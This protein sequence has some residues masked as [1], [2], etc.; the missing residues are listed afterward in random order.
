MNIEREQIDR[1]MSPVRR[2]CIELAGEDGD[3]TFFEGL[4]AAIVGVGET[5]CSRTCVVYDRQRC[6]EILE[7][8]VGDAEEYFEHNVAQAFIG[9]NTP[10][11]LVWVRNEG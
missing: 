6:I 5:A 9:T 10:L 11:F 7:A 1:E 8:L 4:D 2:A 3:L